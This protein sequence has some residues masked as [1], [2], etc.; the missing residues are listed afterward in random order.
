MSGSSAFKRLRLA[1]GFAGRDEDVEAQDLRRD[2]QGLL[3]FVLPLVLQH[4]ADQG[5]RLV[6]GATAGAGEHGLSQLVQAELLHL[7]GQR[8][9]RFRVESQAEEPLGG[10]PGSLD[11]AA[12]HGHAQR[13]LLAPPQRE[14]IERLAGVDEVQ[15]V[16]RRPLVF[17]GARPDQASGPTRLATHRQPW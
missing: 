5:C 14:V 2:L 6:A 9:L 13:Q 3:A 16:G 17:P 15:S 11:L 4:Q 10:L 8:D 1:F 12:G 7:A